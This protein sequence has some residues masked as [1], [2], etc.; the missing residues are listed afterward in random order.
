MPLTPNSANNPTRN[1]NEILFLSQSH[2]RNERNS[3]S[4]CAEGE[5]RWTMGGA[6]VV[7][8]V[9]SVNL[10]LLSVK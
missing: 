1:S 10:F 5:R 2:A 3:E 8:V 7:V 6:E 4:E 9:M